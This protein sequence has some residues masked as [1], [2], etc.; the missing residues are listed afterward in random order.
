MMRPK[1]LVIRRK[2]STGIILTSALM[3]V[4]ILVIIAFAFQAYG[5]GAPKAS[6]TKSKSAA[7]KRA[8]AN[9]Y[10]DQGKRFQDQENYKAAARQYEKAV[11]ADPNYAEAHSNLG[12]SYR[13]QGKFDKA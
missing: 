4:S 3:L 12:F 5:A 7:E 1:A 13:K 6:T 11:K 10:F 9:I 2:K 8:E